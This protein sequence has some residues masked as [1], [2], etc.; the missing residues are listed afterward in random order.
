MSPASRFSSLSR[1]L[2]VRLWTAAPGPGL[3][4]GG[5]GDE[6]QSTWEGA[7]SSRRF[8]LG[9]APQVGPHWPVT[10]LDTAAPCKSCPLPEMGSVSLLFF[11][12]GT[13]LP[14]WFR[15]HFPSP[16]VSQGPPPE[17]PHIHPSSPSPAGSALSH[18]S[19]RSCAHASGLPVCTS[20][21]LSGSQTAPRPAPRL[22]KAPC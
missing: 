16:P 12:P 22:P 17:F 21:H 7:P 10:A 4:D 18:E 15:S 19:S 8:C 11:L 13:G 14:P 6:S 1:R 20:C 2:C 3:P 5:L 9:A